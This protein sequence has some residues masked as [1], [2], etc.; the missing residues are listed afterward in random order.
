[1]QHDLVARLRAIL[2]NPPSFEV[3][4][5]LSA[6]LVEWP[7]DDDFSL[8]QDYIKAHIGLP[9]SLR[10]VEGWSLGPFHI[11]GRLPKFALTP[12]RHNQY[13]ALDQE[14]RWVVIECAN[15]PEGYLPFWSEKEAYITA[16]SKHP[17]P[18]RVSCQPGPSTSHTH[19][20]VYDLHQKLGFRALLE[21]WKRREF[22]VRVG[23]AAS[24]GV[25]IAE[26]FEA[27]HTLF[28]PTTHRHHSH[29]LH[30]GTTFL[31]SEGQVSLLPQYWSMGTLETAAIDWR[32]HQSYHSPFDLSDNQ[33]NDSLFP[34]GVMLYELIKGAHP[35]QGEGSD[36][37]MLTID[38]WMDGELEA[39]PIHTPAALHQLTN[40]LLKQ[41]SLTTL[42]WQSVH[43]A[44]TETLQRKGIPSPRDLMREVSS[45]AFAIHQLLQEY[46]LLLPPILEDSLICQESER[47]ANMR[48]L[49]QRVGE[50]PQE[51]DKDPHFTF[52]QR[53]RHTELWLPES[54]EEEEEWNGI[55]AESVDV[56]DGFF[57]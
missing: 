34:L 12:C 27:F 20:L 32:W 4:T 54:N 38:Q 48:W 2:D 29:K 25:Q 33:H 26:A 10:E 13:L 8:C 31:S 55:I 56:D 3:L 42:D 11:L 52:L 46:A 43:Q 30:P 6:L 14:E 9:S 21:E 7:R 15:R 47:G 37:P 41:D 35:F 49:P 1:M 22:G 50:S 57:S 39:L 44:C 40:Q 18:S 23:V 28:P 53:E 24:L 19:T 36:A 5:Q 51:R 17:H 45:R 16:L